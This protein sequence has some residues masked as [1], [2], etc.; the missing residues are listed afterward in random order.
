MNRKDI[1]DAFKAIVSENKFSD[2][3]SVF[4]PIIEVNNELH[5]L[6]EVRSLA[7]NQQPGE[8]CFPG[9]KIE[10]N[11]SPIQSAIRETVEELNISKENIE[12]IGELKPITT[13][14]D[15]VIYPFCGFIKNIK[16]EDINYSRDEVDSIFSVPIKELLNQNPLVH[17]IGIKLDIAKDFPHDLI[18]K[19]YKWK[20][21]KYPVYFYEYKNHVIWGLTAKITKN[22][23]DIIK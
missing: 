6:Y 21:S 7:L 9:G 4:V 16:I 11:E 23:L 22:F 5:A 1:L 14:F 12:I 17:Q 18:G 19:D 8:V 13:L 15:V 10:P 2:N 20:V 3:Y